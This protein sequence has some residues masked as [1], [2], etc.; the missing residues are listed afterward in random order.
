VSNWLILAAL[1]VGQASI[2][3]YLIQLLATAA[4]YPLV[5]AVS[6]LAFGVRRIAPGDLD[7]LV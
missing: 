5:V 6:A 4:V 1:A 2:G 3:L 7:V